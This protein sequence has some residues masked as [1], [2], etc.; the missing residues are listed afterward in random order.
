MT[1][2]LTFEAFNCGKRMLGFLLF[3]FLVFINVGKCNPITLMLNDLCNELRGI[4]QLL[5]IPNAE[6]SVD[7]NAFMP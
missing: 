6:D 7:G 1:F 2:S 3:V 5:M 4:F